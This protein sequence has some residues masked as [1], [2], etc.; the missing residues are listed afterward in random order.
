MCIA[1]TRIWGNL[2]N[3]SYIL[4][5]ACIG[6]STKVQSKGLTRRLDRLILDFVLWSSDSKAHTTDELAKLRDIGVPFSKALGIDTTNS[7]H[8]DDVDRVSNTR[9]HKDIGVFRYLPGTDRWAS[10]IRI[11]IAQHSNRYY[12]KCFLRLNGYHRWTSTICE[13]CDSSITIIYCGEMYLWDKK[14]DVVNFEFQ[15]YT[16][17]ISLTRWINIIAHIFALIL[18]TKVRDMNLVCRNTAI[19]ILLSVLIVVECSIVKE[20]TRVCSIKS[21]GMF[22]SVF[23]FY[24]VQ[25]DASSIVNW[26]VYKYIA[27]C[28]T[29]KDI[30]GCVWW[31]E[32]CSQ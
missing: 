4:F 20:R 8:R 17:I 11:F 9:V 19:K 2:P 14:F 23:V 26:N 1:G 5:R 30:E 18:R 6:I 16:I 24:F 21:Y 25:L 31:N 22:S 27:K 29:F 7:L 10:R 13:V 32:R 12:I 3:L 15:N 28:N